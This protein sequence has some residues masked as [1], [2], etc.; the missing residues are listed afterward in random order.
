MRRDAAHESHRGLRLLIV[1]PAV[2]KQ[3][4]LAAKTE[5][6]LVEGQSVKADHAG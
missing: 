4:E 1:P 3:K 2:A 6:K 5:A